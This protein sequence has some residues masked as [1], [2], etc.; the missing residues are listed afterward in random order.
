MDCVVDK[1][2]VLIAVHK[3]HHG[4]GGVAKKQKNIFMIKKKYHITLYTFLF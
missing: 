3:I 1:D 2:D 4:L